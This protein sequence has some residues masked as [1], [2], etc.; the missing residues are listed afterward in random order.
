MLPRFV[1]YT[2]I[3]INIIVIH[4]LFLVTFYTTVYGCSVSVRGGFS[5][6]IQ[7]RIKLKEHMYGRLVYRTGECLMR[8]DSLV[9]FP[10]ALIKDER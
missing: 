6:V 8:A 2:Y 3:Y 4:V 1:S 9:T 7:T 5:N 10:S